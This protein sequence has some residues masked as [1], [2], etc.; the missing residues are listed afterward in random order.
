MVRLY[1]LEIINNGRVIQAYQ[2]ENIEE[3]F[4]MV[5]EEF[6]GLGDFL[7]DEIVKLIDINFDKKK[8]DELKEKQEMYDDIYVCMRDFITE[9]N[10]KNFFE[11][12]FESCGID[13][14]INILY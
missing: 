13:Y 3:I 11:N 12:Y 9:E 4:D 5:A 14:K 2:D 10:Y 6:D 8:L 7:H 1:I